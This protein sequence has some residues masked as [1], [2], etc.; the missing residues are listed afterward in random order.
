MTAVTHDATNVDSLMLE[1]LVGDAD[2]LDAVVDPRDEMLQFSSGA[3]GAT[4]AWFDYFR[5]GHELV[6][7]VDQIA[8][9]AFPRERET[10][11]LLEFACG[12]GR[13]VRHL[14]RRFPP[15]NIT[16]SDV[17]P[18][19][20]A[21]VTARFGVSGKLSHAEPESLQW[22]ERYDLIIVP[23]LFSHLPDATFSRW[24]KTLHGLLTDRG[25]LAFSVHDEHLVP[26]ADLSDGISFTAFSE[27]LGRL[28]PEQY[29]TSY[30]T[31]GYVADQVEAATG[32]RRY[33]RIRR[34]FWDDQDVYLTTGPAQYQPQDFRYER[35]IMGHVDAVDCADGTVT[36]SG[37]ARAL[38][39]G[40]TLRVRVGDTV[41]FETD[42]FEARADVADVR[43][44]EFLESGYAVTLDL[45]PAAS[46]G[47]QLLVVDASAG[48]QTTCFYALPLPV[49]AQ[50]EAPGE[51]AGPTSSGLAASLRQR[52]TAV[53]K[54]L[55]ARARVSQAGRPAPE[56]GGSPGR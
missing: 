16:V 54:R 42:R 6:R 38:Q 43:G 17:D 52:W 31:E 4:R 39:P 56:R 11:A 10:V 2:G 20:L 29:G 5:F 41:L 44:P 28:D 33:G 35:P 13:N 23:S 21:F 46:S 3:S 15:D 7:T 45:P 37:W 1:A 32:Q 50:S 36:V 49:V 48:E 30:V 47:P 8:D 34:G 24:L 12:Y 53:G 14:V 19:A 18:K 51:P 27:A 40:L 25:V 26:D 9:W 22:A 55:G